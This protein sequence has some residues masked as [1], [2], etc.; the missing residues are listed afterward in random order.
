MY[1]KILEEVEQERLLLARRIGAFLD[2]I[3][4]EKEENDNHNRGREVAYILS[5]Y[6]E[7]LKLVR[8]DMLDKKSASKENLDV[9]ETTK[10]KV[11][12]KLEEL[13]SIEDLCRK[14][15]TNENIDKLMD[16]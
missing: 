9:L 1:L 14:K 4:Q 7:H 11:K 10:G 5:K 8:D 16:K 12:L 3:G 15:Q 6:R 2:F 13:S